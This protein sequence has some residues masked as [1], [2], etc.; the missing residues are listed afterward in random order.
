MIADPALLGMPSVSMGIRAVPVVAFFDAS[1]AA[2]PSGTPVPNLPPLA[3]HL[4][5]DSVGNQRADGR[6]AARNCT[7][8][9]AD[10]SAA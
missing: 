3:V 5:L 1:G 10:T 2:S 9:A 4:L 8:H 7:D 6:A